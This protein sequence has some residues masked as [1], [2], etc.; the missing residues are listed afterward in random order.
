MPIYE[1]TRTLTQVVDVL[2]DSQEQA[3]RYASQPDVEW[4]DVDLLDLDIRG[5]TD[6]ADANDPEL[7]DIQITLEEEIASDIAARAR[8]E[9]PDEEA[10]EHGRAALALV[11]RNLS[12]SDFATLKGLM[13]P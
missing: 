1:V 3:A 7:A 4:T 10:A 11:L 12:I 5:D 13:G 2:A 6:V 8:I 9:I